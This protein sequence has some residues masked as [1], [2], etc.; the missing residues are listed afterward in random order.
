MEE[1]VGRVEQHMLRAA[2]ET[3]QHNRT[4]AAEL[5]GFT[6]VDQLRYLMRKYNIE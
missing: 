6:K 5:L 1:V 2:L 3:A 4:R